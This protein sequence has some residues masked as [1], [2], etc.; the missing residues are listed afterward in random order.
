[1]MFNPS[2]VP[3]TQ[4]GLNEDGTLSFSD[5]ESINFERMDLIILLAAR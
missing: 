1:M 3:G 2:G 5:T 4:T